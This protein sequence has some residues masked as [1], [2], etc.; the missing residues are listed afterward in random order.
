MATMQHPAQWAAAPARRVIRTSHWGSLN[1]SSGHQLRHRNAMGGLRTADANRRERGWAAGFTESSRGFPILLL[2]L[3]VAL[4]RQA[5]SVALDLG[6]L[7]DDPRRH[8][9]DE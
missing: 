7:S 9:E 1:R 2:E 3:Q 4:D 8:P 5:N 6:R